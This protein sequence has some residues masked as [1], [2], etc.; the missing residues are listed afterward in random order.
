MNATRLKEIASKIEELRKNRKL[1]QLQLAAR[2]GL[3]RPNYNR[4]IKAKQ[5][6]SMASY[7]AIA[8]ALGVP[9]SEILELESNS[10]VTPIE[11][12][13]PTPEEILEI[14]IRGSKIDQNKKD[15]LRAIIR[16]TDEELFGIS[17]AAAPVL[18]RLGGSNKN[19]ASG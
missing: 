9:V 5:A 7:Q 19:Q 14:F 13:D 10:P 11:T 6:A 2:A 16:A 12:R 17:R 4:I 1:T 3:S 18:L 15:L 8:T